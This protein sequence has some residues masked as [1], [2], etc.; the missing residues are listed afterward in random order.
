VDGAALGLPDRRQVGALVVLFVLI[1]G[2]EL[3]Q[4][5]IKTIYLLPR[6]KTRESDHRIRAT[7][8]LRFQPALGGNRRLPRSGTGAMRGPTDEYT[9]GTV[10]QGVV[11]APPRGVQST[12]HRCLGS[13]PGRPEGT[14]RATASHSV[15][16]RTGGKQNDTGC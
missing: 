2:L 16:G 3:V 11:F 1:G 10:V 4:V 7:A 14:R 6:L 13:K 5:P 15:V 9:P 8:A 12:T